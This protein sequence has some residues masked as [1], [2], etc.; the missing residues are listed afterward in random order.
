MDDRRIA[1]YFVVAGLPP[2][3][4]PL[5]DVSRDGTMPCG[6]VGPAPITDLAVIF[7]TLGES[8][9]Q[10]FSL[11]EFTPS[12]IPANLNHG[13]Y[14]T[15]EV[16]LCYRRGR[17]KP[18][19]VDIG[20]MYEGKERI[21]QDA[22]VIKK[23]PYG[24]VANVN[25]STAQIFVTYRRASPSMPCNELV[26][27]DVC[28]IIESKG[29]CP[30]PAFCVLKKN[31]NKGMVGSV[32][33][34]C[35]K[36]SMNRANLI[37][38]KPDILSRYPRHD[39]SNFPFPLS[40][41]LFCLPM[42]ASLEC[43][44]KKAMQPRPVFSTFVLTVSDAS[45]KVYGSAITF[46]EPYPEEQLTDEQLEQLQLPED[47]EPE[48]FTYNV[49]KSIC[50]LSHW[51]F[52]DTF[53]HFLLFLYSMAC[54]GPQP[55]PIE[56]Y[57]S[58]FLEDVPF[59]SPQRPR[60][61]VQLSPAERVILTQ[62]EDLP[63]PRSG[64]RFRSLLINLGPDNCLLVLLCALTE[65][66]LL[67]HSL[68]PDVLTAVAE[69]IS[70]IIFPFK[71]Q[72]PYIP[73]CP[74]GLAEVLH[75][76][77]PFLIGVD[78]RFFDLHDPPADVI[79]VDLDTNLITLC[80]EKRNL[81]TKL[82]P[83]KPARTLRNTLDTLYNK[84]NQS[85]ANYANA[86]LQDSSHDESIDRDFQIKRK[87]QVLEL[88]IQEAFLRFMS[89]ILR[90]Y[91]VYLMPITKAP[92]I[93]T[94][95]P[96]S[97]FNLGGFLRSR[98]KSYHKFFTYVMKTQM[99]I[100]FIEER[101]F[102]SDMDAGLAF[103]DICCE[104]MNSE[105]SVAHLIE[106]DEALNNERTV[107][108]MPPEPPP[109]STASHSYNGCFTLN[110]T[111]FSSKEMNHLLRIGG[112]RLSTSSG[113]LGVPGSPM[114][115]RTKHEVK[116]AQKLARK[117][118]SSP[119]NWAKC[120]VGTCYSLWF[121]HLPSNV[122]M[123]PRKASTCLRTAYDLLNMMQRLKLQPTDEVCYRVMMQLCGVYSTPVLAVKLLFLMK[124]SGVQPNAITYG[125][126]N[127]AVLEATWPSDMNN[128]SQ[129][130]WNKLRNVI[131]GAALFRRAGTKGQVS[132]RASAF[133]E[134]GSSVGENLVD[135]SSHTSSV[136]SSDP[137]N[138]DQSGSDDHKAKNGSQSDTGYSSQSD[139]VRENPG[140]VSSSEALVDVLITDEVG[141]GCDPSVQRPESILDLSSTAHQDGAKARLGLS[142]NTDYA[143]LDRFRSRVGSIVRPTGAS[144]L[145][146][147]NLQ[148]QPF[149]S[150]AGLLMTSQY[151]GRPAPLSEEC[152]GLDAISDAISP[153]L[154]NG[155]VGS[156]GN[157]RRSR[158]RSGSCSDF[159]FPPRLSQHEKNTPFHS[160]L[161]PHSPKASVEPGSPI[162]ANPA[163]HFKILMRSE[164]FANDAGILEKLNKLKL[165]F[166][167]S[168]SEGSGDGKPAQ[169]SINASSNGPSEVTSNVRNVSFPRASTVS[170]A[171]FGRRGS[172]N[173]RRTQ[174]SESRESLSENPDER[175]SA[176]NS[177]GGSTDDLDS[178]GSQ[179]TTPT[180]RILASW[181]NQWN[182]SQWSSRI[183]GSKDGQ[184]PEQ[185]LNDSSNAISNASPSRSLP[186]SPT[187]TPVTENDPLGALVGEIE[188]EEVE[189]SQSCSQEGTEESNHISV[190]HDEEGNPIL[191]GGRR[192]GKNNEK[193]VAR[194]ATFHEDERGIPGAHDS[195]VNKDDP[196]KSKIMQRSS[197]ITMPLDAQSETGGGSVASSI[198]SL[199]SSFKL[200]FSRYSPSRFSLRKA[201][202]RIGQQIIE[203]AI[204]NF[205]PSS[206]TSKK[207]SELLMGGLNSL[208]FAATSVAKKFDE[209]KEA[210]SANNTPSKATNLRDRDREGSYYEDDHQEG[211]CVAD[212]GTNTTRSR[213]VSSEFS[214][215]VTQN[216][217]Y[218]SSN[219]L[220]L[221]GDNSR[222]GS[223]SNLQPLGETSS[224]TSQQMPVL[225]ENLYPKVKRDSRIPVAMKLV[226]TT[227]SKCHNCGSILYDEEI[228]AGW[229]PEDSNLNTKCQFC[230]KATVPFLTVTVM[231]YRS[232]P[233]AST[234]MSQESLHSSP[235]RK[236]SGSLSVRASWMSLNSGSLLSVAETEE[237]KQPAPQLEDA[238]DVAPSMTVIPEN[239]VSP[240]FLTPV[241]EI[242][243]AAPSEAAASTT[244][245]YDTPTTEVAVVPEDSLNEDL[246]EGTTATL[247][248]QEP[249][250]PIENNSP[251]DE[252]HKDSNIIVQDSTPEEGTTQGPSKGD[253][254]ET[255]VNPK[256]EEEPVTL[257]PITVPYLNP[258]VLR[259]ELENILHAEGDVCLTRP[260]FVDEHPIIFWNMVWAM[261]RIAV[262]SHL[263]GLCL[264][265]RSVLRQQT[266]VHPSWS[267]PDHRHVVVR[268]MWDNPR[269][270]EEVGLPMYV[271]WQQDDQHSP[272]VS[273]LLTDRTTVSRPVMEMII[274]SIR[275]ND[276]LEPLRK[277]ATERHKLKGRG[278]TRS[279]SIY[280]DILFL[281]FIVLGRDN[282]HQ[283]SF[284]REYENA[285]DKLPESERKLYLPCDHPLSIPALCCRHYFR[286]LEL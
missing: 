20:V 141:A 74:L 102:V 172:F 194:S 63:L 3:P 120:L 232:H 286:E 113:G 196:K 265:S 123:N 56:R 24:K 177:R 250:E 211:S 273:A 46:Y 230:E 47:A 185:Q 6:V 37:S 231:D 159:S 78:S 167:P 152:E 7:P 253:A 224:V 285:F 186:K 169:P 112:G 241:S 43:W 92:T 33:Y 132:R 271:L 38:Y 119:E 199:G 227:C 259:K 126:Y 106:L 175:S 236:N 49:N 261:E 233:K 173:F 85:M 35:Y 161:T 282:I 228:M 160:N 164:S 100:R 69:A 18:P 105:D 104:K 140:F 213:K 30:P 76:P 244:S 12:G 129:L 77:L 188:E 269:L 189:D 25:N 115:R 143:A 32:V 204:T 36:K 226:L 97:L 249:V 71:W 195:D 215:S 136:D 183:W 127:R 79:C 50:L 66:K 61:L 34:L 98:D 134:E 223:S 245:D 54:S 281:A 88:E 91:R 197:T 10:G 1:D 190:G 133:V 157:P 252:A 182:N 209:I 144:L 95:D 187:R 60:I 237:L 154:E 29:E 137:K 208:K 116:S 111:L 101:S 179:H 263:P 280:R 180:R 155:K 93:G 45:E 41:P 214:P 87:E 31:L 4:Q 130:L 272:L 181:N 284:D 139:N 170:K 107:F 58:H 59:P 72:C 267:H 151:D 57:I 260:C 242:S 55:V 117:S 256:P 216:L 96:N 64:A 75:A 171:L 42:G 17:D 48:E 205:S 276:L 202:L 240:E 246:V 99:F 150:S 39:H 86:G 203:N 156:P 274:A 121:I 210:V 82:L 174:N 248:N 44:P 13:S 162:A 158:G 219:L 16:Y 207:S 73:L 2:Q 109:N 279:H 270:H 262:E 258:L 145:S 65:Q 191:F 22:E 21:M 142:N 238:Q 103:F 200:P 257:E 217:E 149:E 193:G 5:E 225:P 268:C 148:Q 128:S 19:L 23:T 153:L 221:F 81:N 83:K 163:E 234:G 9:P 220:D 135:G 51:P 222:K 192:T 67:V 62:P 255:T 114:A 108:I 70:M 84:V 52:F 14:R 168:L 125:F 94:T 26:V 277:L 266:N 176:E 278:V 124:R 165:G 146:N 243:G 89:S 206:L 131:M 27:T 138:N 8:P 247:T 254:S 166:S 118:A 218:W 15:P 283:A 122:M 212:D 201:D 251:I 147:S 11:L 28:V 178:L 264:Q 198:G 239:T 184:T 40:V 275:C 235:R 110:P 68:R 229:S 80:E 90:G 53:E